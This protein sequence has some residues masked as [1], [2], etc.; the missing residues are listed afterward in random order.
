MNKS[1]VACLLT[2]VV[3]SV[4]AANVMAANPNGPIPKCPLGQIPVLEQGHYQCQQ[5][6]IKAKDSSAR[7]ASAKTPVLTPAKVV[8]PDYAILGAKRVYGKTNTFAVTVRNNG[9]ATSPA[10]QIFGAHY[11]ADNSS[12]GADAIIPS[13]NPGQ[14]KVINIT[15]PPENYTRGDRIK[16]TADNFKQVVESNENNNSYA[17]NYN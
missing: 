7:N 5:P 17:M 2:N 10:N 4:L 12:W 16:F 15:I 13:L 1:T 9:T 3:L 8:L 6:S 11:L 14:T